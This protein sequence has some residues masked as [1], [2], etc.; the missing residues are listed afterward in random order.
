MEDIGN[1][2]LIQLQSIAST[3]RKYYELAATT[4]LPS[5]EDFE[6][7][8]DTLPEADRVTF[9]ARGMTHCWDIPAFKRFVYEGRG[10]RLENFLRIY[11][12]PE[13]YSIWASI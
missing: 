13:E 12:T 11:L 6:N 10:H 8:L 1:A 7:W 4:V 3:I 2:S 5:K 9:A